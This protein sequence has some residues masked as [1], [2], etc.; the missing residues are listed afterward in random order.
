MNATFGNATE[1]IISIYALRRGMIRVVQQSLLG[2]ILSN[3]LLVLGCAFFAGGVVVSKREQV[4]SKVCFYHEESSWTLI[5]YYSL[6]YFSSIYR[7]YDVLLF[8][9]ICYCEFWI[10]VNGSN[11][12]SISCCPSV[13]TYR[14][15]LWKVRVGSFKI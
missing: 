3:M 5:N 14:V 11:G 6:F 10:A 13:H 1:L 4:F 7:L 2:S 12:T 9:G 15:A 8:L